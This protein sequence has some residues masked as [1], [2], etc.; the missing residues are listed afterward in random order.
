[1]KNRMMCGVLVL[2]AIIC[3]TNFAQSELEGLSEKIGEKWQLKVRG[4]GRDRAHPGR[5][6][7]S[8]D[9]NYSGL[10]DIPGISEDDVII[11]LMTKSASIAGIPIAFG[12]AGLLSIKGGAGFGQFY[13]PEEIK[14]LASVAQ[15][16][17]PVTVILEGEVYR[18]KKDGQK[19]PLGKWRA[20]LKEQVKLDPW[21]LKESVQNV[22]GDFESLTV[23]TASSWNRDTVI[24]IG[25]NGWYEWK[26]NAAMAKKFEDFKLDYRLLP[27]HLT[28]LNK[29]IEDTGWLTA[30]VPERSMIDDGTEYTLTLERAGKKTAIKCHQGQGD[31]SYVELFRLIQRINRQEWLYYTAVHS[32]KGKRDFLRE[33]SQEVRML[34][35]KSGSVYAPMLDYQRIVPTFRR[36]MDKPWGRSIDEVVIAIN[37]FT[38]LKDETEYDHIVALSNDL[39]HY[40]WRSII[41]AMRRFGGERSV[42]VVRSMLKSTGH[43]ASKALV[44]M[45]DVAV[46]TIA[47]EIREGTDRNYRAST[48]LVRAYIDNWDNIQ[49][50]LDK[51][52]IDA[53]RDAR[54]ASLKGPR[55][56]RQYHE[57]LL[58]LAQAK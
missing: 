3:G 55:S 38:Y 22:Q 15:G 46:P 31:K 35:G 57:Q 16:K 32:S 43:D 30:P 10:K 39:D 51:R 18:E 28:E 41:T 4:C 6:G 11:T 52:I 54:D 12:G 58:E 23:T 26:L 2:F 34:L 5:R 49:K 8:I 7:I 20:E 33:M 40:V 25:K 29:L 37:L 42:K 50:P 24:T 1:M 36:T 47:D 9:A 19:Q 48:R 44:A 53:T 56:D 13:L 14:G 45:G 17:Y 21:V 27:E